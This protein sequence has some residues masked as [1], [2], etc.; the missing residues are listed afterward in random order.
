VAYSTIV[1]TTNPVPPL[2]WEGR[3]VVSEA[4]PAMST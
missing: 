2:G 1:E 4:G 3:V